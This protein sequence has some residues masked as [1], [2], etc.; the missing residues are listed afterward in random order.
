[1]GKTGS[2]RLGEVW[3]VCEIG[4]ADCNPNS[5]RKVNTIKRRGIGSETRKIQKRILWQN[6]GVWI[7]HTGLC[8]SQIQTS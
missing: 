2:G 5:C 4:A 3:A 7:P 6:Q 1:M 8:I